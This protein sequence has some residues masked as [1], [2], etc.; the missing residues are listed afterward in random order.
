[1]KKIFIDCDVTID[2]ISVRD[3]YYENAADI[4]LPI[5]N[6]EYDGY[7]S[8]LSFSHISYFLRKYVKFSETISRM[9]DLRKL[10]KVCN[11]DSLV[12]DQSLDSK[13]S[14]FEDALQ[15]HSALSVK[16]DYI[17]TRN[18][19]DFKHSKIKVLSPK[20]FLSKLPQ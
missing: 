12:I 15:Y 9:K 5:Q 10:V 6:K 8:S 19:K 20:E 2:F 14:D 18:A 3:P 13:F 17:I 11:V 16:A 1:M 7:I 4:F